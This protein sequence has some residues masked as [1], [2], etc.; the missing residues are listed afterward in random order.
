M[1]RLVIISAMTPLLFSVCLHAQRAVSAETA[2]ISP[3]TVPGD[4]LSSTAARP[5]NLPDAPSAMFVGAAPVFADP[6]APCNLAMSTHSRGVAAPSGTGVAHVDPCPD[7][8]HRFL[9]STRPVPLSPEQKAHLAIHNMLDRGNLATIVGTAGFNVG[10]N[11][12]SRRM[13]RVGRGLAG[14]RG[15]ACC[16]MGRA[17]FSGRS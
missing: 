17:S 10:M 3:G 8:F 4:M 7:P 16:R 9:D 15:T 12:H 5:Q 1:R 11:S 13:G 2:A 6:M 14:I